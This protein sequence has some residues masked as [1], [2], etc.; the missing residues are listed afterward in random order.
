MPMPLL[1]WVTIVSSTLMPER[2]GTSLVPGSLGLLL[3]LRH[4]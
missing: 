1:P 2:L 3:G 4:Y